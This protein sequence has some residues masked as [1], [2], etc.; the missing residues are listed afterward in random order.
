MFWSSSRVCVVDAI[1]EFLNHQIQP[2]H[3]A[4]E[5]NDRSMLKEKKEGNRERRGREGRGG[6][7]ERS[8]I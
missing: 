4:G 3:T 7:G 6:E 1:V 5:A 2:I 8:W